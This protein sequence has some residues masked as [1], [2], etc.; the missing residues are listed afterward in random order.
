M[1]ADNRIENMTLSFQR[2]VND[3][4]S[5]PFNR[6]ELLLR[7]TTLINLKHSVAEAIALARD[8]NVVKKQ[9]EDLN[10]RNAESERKMD[11]LI[12]Y[13]KLKTEFFT[14]ISHELRTPLN[15][16]SSTVQ[17]LKSLDPTRQL[18]E[19]SI[20]KYLKI[21]NNNCYRLLRL[22]N[23]LIDTTRLDGGYIKL[24]L[25]NN[26]IVSVIEDITQ[27]VAEY[28]KSKNIDIIFDT[29]VERSI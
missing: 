7:V 9:V 8:M 2:G 3:Y 25:K 27:S 10:L 19:E 29:E 24:H 1:T 17:L 12:E 14:N 13:D 5:K 18:G 20:R 6:Q 15:V 22:I 21:M 28:I 16:I 23:N 11:E 4:L 26:N